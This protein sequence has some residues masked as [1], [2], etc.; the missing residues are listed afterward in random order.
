[1]LCDRVTCLCNRVHAWWLTQS[2]LTA[3]LFNCRRNEGSDLDVQYSWLGLNALSLVGP[4]GVQLLDICCSSISVRV[5]LLSSHLV[6]TQSCWILIYRKTGNFRVVQ[7][8]R[9][10]AVSINSRKLKSTKYFP[11]FEKI[12]VEEL[13]AYTVAICGSYLFTC[14]KTSNMQSSKNSLSLQAI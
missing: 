1:M 4:I 5:L 2:Q 8:S 6:S 13:V 14:G 11:I 10:F 12:S 9:N 3:S 7:F